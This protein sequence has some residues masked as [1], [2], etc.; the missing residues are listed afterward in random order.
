M[1]ESVTYQAIV[2]EGVQKGRLEEAR[3]I[4]LRMGE[5]RFG[6]PASAKT[7]AR[8][9]TVSRLEVLEH[10]ADRVLWVQSWDELLA[11]IPTSPPRRTRKKS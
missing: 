5:Q 4:L 2:E 7:R 8:L 1:K 6:K 11:E 3:H 10:L 9:E